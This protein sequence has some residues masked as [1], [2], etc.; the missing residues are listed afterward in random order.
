MLVGVVF[1][2][3]LGPILEK[4][5]TLMADTLRVKRRTT[6]LP[7]APASLANAEIAYNEVNHIL[8]YGEGTGGAG[9]TA[10]VVVAVG[11][12]GLF[13]STLPLMNGAANA[14]STSTWTRAD[15]V[16]PTD[17]TLAPI[18]SPNFTGIPLSPTAVLGTNTTQIATT[19]FV[20]N[21][22]G[23]LPVGVSSVTTGAGLTGGGTGNVTIAVSANGIT[24][25][26]LATMPA[27]TIK[28]NQSGSTAAAADLTVAQLMTMLGAAPIASP[29]F[30]GTPLA[31]TAANGTNTTQIATTQYVL[32]V[33]HDQLQPPTNDVSWNNHKL[34][35]LLDPTA[36]Q[37]A[38]TKNYVDITVQGMSAKPTA[39]LATAAPL[40]AYTYN[41]GTLGV[42][43]TLIATANGA[44]TVDGVAVSNNQLVVVKNEAAQANN[45]LYQVT[46]TGS[47]AAPYV[48]TRQVDM[49]Q[50][51]EMQGA[52]VPVEFG[53]IN[54]NTL[55]LANP[56][57][58]IVV[59][60]TAIPWVQLNAATSINAGNGISVVGTTISAVGTANRIVVTGPGID[61]AANYSGQTSIT[62]VGT[63]GIGTWNG[64]VIDV[65]HG[66]TSATTLTGYT[67]GHG[68][69]AFTA[70]TTIPNTDIT[71]L[72]TMS[73]QNASAVAITGGTIDGVVIDGGTF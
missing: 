68:A 50:A 22:I 29:S 12:P 40:P 28:G 34:V 11:G 52:F 58:P 9:G 39:Q 60:T 62:A 57:A 48:L 27:L 23:N 31:P 26:L 65:A 51:S 21:A 61:I 66:G 54:A 49:D 19:A 30:T 43:A 2:I 7:G 53:T 32:A 41:N 13:S 64:T 5:I 35:N 17:T 59:G 37:D 46:N 14:G 33:R 47:I 15:H 36:P 69:G 55:W 1:Q 63:I 72:G 25:S 56:I 44:L 70:S 10:T 4:R 3:A 16:H 45:G 73:T 24:N 18:A 6:G 38:A 71:G 67:Y 8:Y 42:G 20:F